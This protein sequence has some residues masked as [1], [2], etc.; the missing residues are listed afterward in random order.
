MGTA[1]QDRQ[2]RAARQRA[3]QRDGIEEQALSADA[4]HGDGALLVARTHQPKQQQ[5]P[6]RPPW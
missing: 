6:V 3:R 2:P 4:N 1:R 5:T